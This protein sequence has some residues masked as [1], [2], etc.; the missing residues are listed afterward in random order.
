MSDH[1][2]QHSLHFWDVFQLLCQTPT[3]LSHAFERKLSHLKQ[4]SGD[5]IDILPG[6]KKANRRYQDRLIEVIS[7]M[8][9]RIL[10][11]FDPSVEDVSGTLFLSL[12]C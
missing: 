2:S 9:S 7:I 11:Q 10:Q 1:H 12:A 8:A 3:F 4:C 5:M 6:N